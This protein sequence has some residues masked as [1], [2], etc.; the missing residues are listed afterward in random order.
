MLVVDT[1]GCLVVVS[2]VM[3]LL[4]RMRMVALR[5]EL[6]DLHAKSLVGLAAIHHDMLP[7]VGLSVHSEGIQGSCL[8]DRRRA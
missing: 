4:R 8:I 2:V 3:R 6:R 1:V 7:L 5:L